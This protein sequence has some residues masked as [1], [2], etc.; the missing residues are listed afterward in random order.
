MDE[1]QIVSAREMM[2]RKIQVWW[3]VGLLTL[4]CAILFAA[5]VNP[6]LDLNGD[7]ASYIRLAR[8]LAEGHGY[9]DVSVD[10]SYKPA[11]HFPPGYPA[12][13]SVFVRCGMDSLTGFKVLNGI[14][15]LFSVLGLFF[16]V[17]RLTGQVWWAFSIAALTFFSPV[18]LQFSGMVMSEMSYM[19]T[20]VAV[21]YALFRYAERGEGEW[22]KSPWFYMAI[23]FSVFSYHIRTVGASAMFAVVVFFF[24]RK[25]WRA[26]LA[27]MTGIFL[28]LLP[29][30][31][32]NAAYGIKGR[33][34]GT[35]MTVNPWRPE[36]GTISS[37][38]EMVD[39]MIVNLNDTV[40]QG[41]QELL[42]PFVDF[43][44]VGAGTVLSGS[45]VFAVVVMG[46]WNMGK[47]RWAMLAFLAGNIGLFALWHGG[48]GTR[49][50]TPLVP[51]LFVFFYV[52]I[53]SLLQWYRGK[54]R[55]PEIRRDS[56]WGLLWLLLA[57][58]MAGP[59]GE[60][61][62]VAKR[63]YPMAYSHYFNLARMVDNSVAEGTVVC[64]RK[65]EL[66]NYFSPKTRATGYA[67]SLD[68]EEVVRGMLDNGVDYVVLEQ[69]GYGSTGRYLYPAILEY[70]SV[71][72][73]IYRTPEPVT[74][75][76]VFDKSAAEAIC[77]K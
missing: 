52:G 5:T 67:F 12:L 42:F 11:S 64:C 34:L 7:N 55:M 73:E 23:L 72:K 69:L 70:P 59:V 35:V 15:L 29:W 3:L 36:M 14:F 51:F 40:I 47:M 76:Y 63:P 39:K 77:R 38:G 74:V 48:N 27:S 13:L 2:K 4:L 24:F 28:G 60:L 45:I 66:F 68:P 62:Q 37:V 25:E 41:F 6:K 30:I 31:W 71:F 56:R 8:I 75:L 26:G 49:Y 33:Y 22:Y 16:I 53:L 21:M 10:G 17:R 44:A 65:P 54:R 18:L 50:V 9:S 58:P 20:T 61:R 46:A 43:S 32:R 57:V 19:F 1:V